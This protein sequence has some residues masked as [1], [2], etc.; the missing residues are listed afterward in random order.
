MNLD[1]ICLVSAFV[2]LLLL[3]APTYL[4]LLAGALSWFL[5]HPEIDTMMILQKMYG[6]LDS[7]VLLAV[8]MF[9]ISGSLMNTGS[10]SDR[11]FGFARSLAG[12]LRGGLGHVNIICSF[13]F[14]GMSGS[15]LADVGGQSQI[16]VRAMQDEGYE[17]DLTLG[18]TLAS[19]TM[20]PIVPPSIPMV[21]Y[22]ATAGVSIGALFMGGF[23]PGL[24]MMIVMCL[25]TAYICHKRNYPTH[26]KATWGQR[27]DAFKRAI[28][29]L[30]QPVIVMGG[31]WTGRFTPTEASLVSVLYTIVLLG[32]IYRELTVKQVINVLFDTARNFVPALACVAASALFGW[33]MQFERLDKIM[34]N[35][36]VETLGSKVLII[37]CLNL[38]L[39]F[40]GM[41]LDATPVI[42]LMVPLL[43]PLCTAAGIH[44]VH[45]GVMIVL[46]LMI[47]LMTPPIGQSL[48]VMAAC[49]RVP[50]DYVVKNSYKWLF[51]LLVALLIVSY[52]PPVVLFLPRLFGMV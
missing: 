14:S 25:Y 40:F 1:L 31:M 16:E 45:M 23:F 13:I 52:V 9:M 24:V 51:P 36:F 44:P 35:F 34:V 33:I 32:F 49:Q 17:D 4:A 19:A 8:P 20:G 38:L 11:I 21:I 39:L 29:P 6:S 18:I 26:P 28:L 30:L 48:F 27:V 15:A 7:F 46:N 41:I 10:I 22:G 12:H 50:F 5:F 43:T 2:I 42:M 37:L 47:G 3:G